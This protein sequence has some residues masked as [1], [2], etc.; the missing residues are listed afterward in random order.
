MLSTLLLFCSLA[1]AE[2][3]TLALQICLDREGF[4]CN[5]I[6]GQWGR[7]SQRALESYCKDRRHA[8]PAS[9]E[10]A[11]DTLFPNAKDLFRI[12]PVTAEDLAALVTMPDSP[13]E[14][15]K[16]PKM[17]Y[18]TI[19]AMFAERGHLSQR[20]L[21]RMN[22]GVDWA[23]IQPGLKLVIPDFPSADEEL[24]VWPKR[25]N[26]PKRPEAAR[27]SV[28]LFSYEISAWDAAGRQIA[29]F[30]C[31]IARDKSKRP[32][33]GELKIT[34][35]I[36][37]PNYTYTPDFVPRGQKKQKYVLPEG[38]RC[39]VGIAWLGLNLPGYGIHGTPFPETI[40]RAESHGCFRL[41]NWNAARLYALCKPG[42]RVIIEDQAPLTVSDK[43]G[44]G[45]TRE[46]SGRPVAP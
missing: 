19:K 45:T 34:G 44:N 22:P 20:A 11:Y 14:K 15:A 38:P 21:E 30:P 24:S 10:E 26:G 12:E 9:P 33:A 41:A 18:A 46:K 8:V 4:S 29:L 23:H 7:K 2:T 35:P 16:L 36:A 17:G 40:G 25:R 42:T 6:D 27:V 5:T 3:K 39:P 43:A 1:F 31:S 13:A 37:N 32:T 28:S